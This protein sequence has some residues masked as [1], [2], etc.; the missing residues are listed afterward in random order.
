M[1]HQEPNADQAKAASQQEEDTETDQQS[2]IGSGGMQ[3]EATN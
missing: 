3:D 2:I 1:L